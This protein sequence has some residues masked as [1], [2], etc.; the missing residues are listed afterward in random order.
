MD[1][2]FEIRKFICET[3]NGGRV[4]NWQIGAAREA[5][6]ALEAELMRRLDAEHAT[7]DKCRLDT[8]NLRAALDDTRNENGILRGDIETAR[9]VHATLRTALATAQ[10]V[11]GEELTRATDDFVAYQDDI[12]RRLI[13]SVYALDLPLQ[14]Q[15]EKFSDAKLWE[16]IGGGI[17]ELKKLRAEKMRAW[18]M[19]ENCR[20][21]CRI[22]LEAKTKRATDRQYLVDAADIA[23]N[24]LK[25]SETALQTAVDALV[26]ER[27]I[28]DALRLER[29]AVAQTAFTATQEAWREAKNALEADIERRQKGD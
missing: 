21:T 23:R 24:L 2:C 20:E 16:L 9:A 22:V 19:P 1:Y 29:L 27:A 5:V 12:R 25:S 15:A 3:E 7:I 14:C 13:E 28:V 17:E 26:E 10:T 8:D 6:N 4:S 18:R 11:Q